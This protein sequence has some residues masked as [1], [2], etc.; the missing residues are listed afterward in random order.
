[1]KRKPQIFT[2]T[3]RQNAPVS[4]D[5]LDMLEDAEMNEEV[6]REYISQALST[7]NS[8][9][10]IIEQIAVNTRAPDGLVFSSLPPHVLKEDYITGVLGIKI[11]LNESYPYSQ[12][13]QEEIIKEHLIFEGFFSK[14][15]NM[16][17]DAKTIMVAFKKIAG[18]P[19]L[20]GEYVAAINDGVI[21]GPFKKII[22]F[23]KLITTKVKEWGIKAFEK[24]IGFAESA[25]AKLEEMWKAASSGDGWK[26]ALKIS[27]LALGVMWI[28]KKFGKI[29]ESGSGKIKEIAGKVA[30]MVVGGKNESYIPAISLVAAYDAD[31]STLEELFGFGKKKKK[32]SGDNVKHS[33]GAKKL[34]KAEDTVDDLSQKKDDAEKKLNKTEELLSDEEL[35]EGVDPGS[36]TKETAGVI[37]SA[38]AWFNE[39]VKDALF[40]LFKDMLP[41]LATDL[42]AGAVSGGAG[43]FISG[44]KK[45]FNGVG[46]VTSTLGPA[47]EKFAGRGEAKG[48]D[49]KDDTANTDGTTKQ[50]ALVRAYIRGRL[51]KENK[52][53]GR[54]VEGILDLL[55][56]YASNTWIFFDTETTG[57]HP[58]SA[59]LT[60]IGAIAVDPNTWDSEA[61]ILDQFNEKISFTPETE[62]L[63]NDPGSEERKEWEKKN[64]QSRRPLD[65]PQD[66]LAMTR[67][68]E[69]GR[70]YGDEQDILDQFFEWAD[71]FPNPLLIAQNASFDLKFLNVRSEGKLP[72]YPVL[73]TMQLMQYYLV[74]LLKT[75]AKASE[76]DPEAQELL[77]KLYIKK[78][79]WGYHSVSMGVVSKAY[80]INIDDWHNALADVKMM[81]EMYRNVV[82]TIRKGMGTD[83]SKEQGKVLS[84]QRKRKKRR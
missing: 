56:G 9:E 17:G 55:D 39:N 45:M 78:G 14:I 11:P 74:P 35:P 38:I 66:V 68:G 83:I 15:V 8:T 2:Q 13:L 44:A 49:K 79:N 31:D 64:Q 26:T 4:L 53:S 6:L 1:M 63:M 19:K 30:E 21:Q 70:S 24:I 32:K 33:K 82:S 59:Q 50:E 62:K 69:K 20:A 80:G 60:E 48:D 12:N 65:K 76:G 37:K 16:A 41:S 25:M 81:M 10:N 52:L 54:T 77:D 42:I 18:D 46:F 5:I 58:G 73:D 71:G 61:S 29:I 36:V 28:W 51:L 3:N 47:L 7:Y 40:G 84:R 75:Q 57:M 72:K 23:L 27:G 22:E 43:A 67:Y 34:K